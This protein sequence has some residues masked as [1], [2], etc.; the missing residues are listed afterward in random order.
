[1]SAIATSARVIRSSSNALQAVA[2]R[3]YSSASQKTPPAATQGHSDKKL[4]ITSGVSAV[5][6]FDVAY[7]YYNFGPGSKPPSAS[8][9]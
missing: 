6:G 1:M 2:R 7:V 3:S 4:A 9:D 8:S 5:L